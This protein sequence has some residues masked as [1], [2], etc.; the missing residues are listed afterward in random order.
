MT[1]QAIA[2]G[3][4]AFLISDQSAGSFYDDLGGRIYE[5]V[6]AEEADMPLMVYTIITDPPINYLGGNTDIE[7]QIQIDL[8]GEWRLGAKALGDIHSK[9]I[10]ALEGADITIAGH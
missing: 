5:A 8:Y 4:G 2:T 9:V 6:A 3:F 7:A 1:T 10:T